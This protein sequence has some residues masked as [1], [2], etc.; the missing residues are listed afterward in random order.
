MGDRARGVV[1][2]FFSEKSMVDRYEKL[3]RG[4]GPAA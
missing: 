4:L 1:E 3:L 2:V